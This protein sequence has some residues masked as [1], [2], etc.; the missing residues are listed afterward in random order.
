MLHFLEVKSSKQGHE[1]D[2]VYWMGFAYQKSMYR[3]KTIIFRLQNRFGG[4]ICILVLPKSP[5]QV[6][7]RSGVEQAT[8]PCLELF[9]SSRFRPLYH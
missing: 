6:Q 1:G 3:Q 5:K 9:Q 2:L 8:I 7:S 4:V